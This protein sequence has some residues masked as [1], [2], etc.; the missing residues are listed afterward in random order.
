MKNFTKPKPIWYIVSIYKWLKTKKYV[1]NHCRSIF[2][3]RLKRTEI[4]SI[5]WQK[6]K[7]LLRFSYLKSQN[8]THSTH[9]F[10]NSESTNFFNDF[11][12]NECKASFFVKIN[13]YVGIFMSILISTEDFYLSEKE[14]SEN[15]VKL[16]LRFKIR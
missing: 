15:V 13:S 4:L 1:I 16:F 14:N 6:W 3:I 10:T 11:L 12:L 9:F 7:Y 5:V 2:P 8:F